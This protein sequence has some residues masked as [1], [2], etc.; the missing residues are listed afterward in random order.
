MWAEKSVHERVREDKFKIARPKRPKIR[1]WAD[2]DDIFKKELWSPRSTN[3][4]RFTEIF[5]VVPNVVQALCR[6]FPK[7][8][9]TEF[10]SGDVFLMTLLKLKG[11]RHVDLDFAFNNAKST[12]SNALKLGFE[13]VGSVD[14]VF[15]RAFPSKAEQAE[16]IKTF[17][18]LGLPN[19]ESIF[20]AD[21]GMILAPTN[22]KNVCLL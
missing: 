20:V 5:G 13:A 9:T 15:T 11:W 2:Y 6:K 7:F 18:E 14:Y 16:M 19:P 12:V 17:R 21:C 1:R 3:W 8:E 4:L 22:H 10:E